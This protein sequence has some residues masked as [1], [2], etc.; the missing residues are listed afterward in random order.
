MPGGTLTTSIHHAPPKH[1]TPRRGTSRRIAVGLT[2]GLFV[3]AVGSFGPSAV[4]AAPLAGMPAQALP[5]IAVGLHQGSKGADVKALQEA[6]IAAG[7]TVAGGADGVFGP[8]TRAAVASFQT[9]KGLAVS[10][11]VD[12]ATSAALSGGSAPA[13]STGSGELALGAKGDAVKALQVA[14]AGAGVY[15]PGGPDGVFGAATEKA[16]KSFQRWNGLPV[17]GVADSAT[18]AKLAAIAPAAGAPAA[19]TP[20]ASS[21]PSVGLKMGAQGALVKAL[22]QALINS[23]VAVR[24]GADGA[25]GAATKA[26]LISYQSANG[27]TADGVVDEATATK[28]GLGAA[29]AAPAASSNPYVGLKIGAQGSRVKDLQR[30]LMNTGLALRGG[31]DGAFGAAT[32]AVLITF[33]TTNG[34]APTGIVGE[35]DATLLGLSASGAGTPQG[36]ATTVG[37]PVFGERGDRVKT[38]QQALLNAGIKVPGGADGIFGSSTAGAI[39]D[40]QRREGIAVTGKIDDQTAGKLGQA[41]APAPAAPSA[42]GITIQAFP[43]QG[44]CWFGDTWHAPRGGGRL[45]EGLDII[46]AEGKQL[47]AVVDGTITKQY[48][49]YPGALSGNGVRVSLPNG[50]YFTYLHMS[51]FA[52]GIGVGVPVKAGQLI[53]YVGETGNAAT[54]HLHFEVHPSG[55]GAVNPYPIIKPADA[56]SNT[57]ARG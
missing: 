53:G 4:S 9:A 10:G 52:D 34:T 19:A 18:L 43:V 35:Q 3:G 22:Q 31:A 55:G 11:E 1:R 21:N 8:S 12:A 6:L 49:D 39:M 14:L 44:A 2:L 57:T 51:A 15:L 47:Y 23:G 7:I 50:T 36:I 33:Q 41:A 32:Q 13:A 26:A 42:S 46:A 5:T 28:L 16:V 29:A 45:H 40:F 20:A 17:T 37:Y 30:G 27:L 56:C 38:M 54:P 25:F 48:V 24:G